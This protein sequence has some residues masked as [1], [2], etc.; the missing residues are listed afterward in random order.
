MARRSTLHILGDAF[1]PHSAFLSDGESVEVH[2]RLS[3][4][5]VEVQVWRYE[6]SAAGTG[7]VHDLGFGTCNCP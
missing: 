7:A 6:C 1:D 4:S 2:V 5:D 3:P